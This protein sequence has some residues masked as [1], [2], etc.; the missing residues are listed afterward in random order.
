MTDAERLF[1]DPDV[2]LAA[3]TL[4]EIRDA[5]SSKPSRIERKAAETE[6]LRSLTAEG[7]TC[8]VGPC[9]ATVFRE[10]RG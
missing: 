8:V 9:G 2:L 5:T 7:Y 4:T 3:D 6:R 10:F 1:D